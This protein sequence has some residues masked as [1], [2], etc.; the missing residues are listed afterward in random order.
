MTNAKRLW[1]ISELYYPEQTST[2]YF[3][4]KIAEG[5]AEDYEVKALC[6]RPTYSEQGMDAPRNEVHKGVA[7][8]R[9]RATS[10][11]KDRL[12]LRAINTITLTLSMAWHALWHVRRG[13]RILIVTNPPSI[14]LI[15]GVIAKLKGASA[16]LLVH[17]VYPEVLSATGFLKPTS[18]LYRFLGWIFSRS[19]RG[20]RSIVVLGRDMAD[21]MRAKVAPG[22]TTEVTIIPNWGDVDELGPVERESN[23]FL[24]ANAIAEPCVI[25]FSGN[26]GRTHDVETI[27]AAARRLYEREDI[28]FVFVGF[29]GKA[30]LIMAEEAKGEL[31]N[32]RFLPRQPREMLGP[33]LSSATATIIPF[34]P[35]MRGISV[36]SRMYNI[37]ATATPIIAMAEGDSELS[38]VVTEEK[39]GWVIAPGDV[40]ALVAL[41][42]DIADHVHSAEITARGANGRL[43]A[44]RSYHLGAVLDLYRKLFG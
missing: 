18:P 19:A 3:L 36:P 40:D 23:P 2:G 7:I 37:M 22:S 27:L 25:Q 31:P 28:V 10:F 30:Q 39:A 13:D 16:H 12:A 38:M 11:P 1:V 9:A 15:I 32:I 29:G 41:I 34:I 17:D 44:E 14:P 20:F 35:K 6:G 24:K 33:M 8:H 42:E 4:T 5:L 26:I 21:I 43:A